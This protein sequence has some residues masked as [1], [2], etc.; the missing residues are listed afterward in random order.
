MLRIIY[1][2]SGKRRPTLYMSTPWNDAQNN[3]NLIT[4]RITTDRF[5]SLLGWHDSQ[6]LS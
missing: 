1:Y 6:S 5:A 3:P 2:F 4:Y